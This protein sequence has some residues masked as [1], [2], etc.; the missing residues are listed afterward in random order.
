MKPLNFARVLETA[1]RFN[2]YVGVDKNSSSSMSIRVPPDSPERARDQRILNQLTNEQARAVAFE[3]DANGV[4]RD[5]RKTISDLASERLIGSNDLTPLHYLELAVSIARG[6]CR[7]RIGTDAGTGVLVGPRILMTNNHVIEDESQARAFEAQFDYQE[8]SSGDML[9]V[10]TFQG[11]PDHFF[12]TNAEL[13][14]TLVGLSAKSNRGV[15]IEKFPWSKLIGIPGK[16]AKGDPLNIIQHP[17]G[18]LKQ[19]AIRNNSIIKITDALP[20]F[21]YYT[22]DTQKGSSGSPCFNAHWEMVALHHDAMPEIKNSEIMTKSG[23]PWRKGID[24]ESMIKWIANEGT[25]VSAIVRDLKEANLKSSEEVIR[26]QMLNEEP[27]NP[28]EL[29]RRMNGTIE[30][31]CEENVMKKTHQVRNSDGSVSVNIPLH[32]NVALGASESHSV[33][34][35]SPENHPASK[36]SPRNLPNPRQITLADIAKEVAEIDPDWSNR[37][38]FEEDFLGMRVPLPTLSDAQQQSSV[39]VPAEFRRSGNPFVLDYYNYSVAMNSDRCLAWYSAAIIDGDKR[40]EMPDRNDKWFIDPRIDDVDDVQ[41]QCGEELYATA[42]TDRGHLTRY[43]DVAWGDTK[44]E[45]IRNAFDTLHFTNCCLMLQG[46]NRKRSRW[47]GIERFL[48]EKKAKREL[49]KLI[50]FT[51][52]LFDEEDPYYENQFMDYSVPIPKAFWKVCGIVRRDGT[53]SATAFVLRQDDVVGLPGFREAFTLTSEIQITIADLEERTGLQFDVLRDHDHL[54]DGGA[55]S[56]LE[57]HRRGE[58]TVAELPIR[59]FDDVVV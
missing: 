1:D 37:N 31:T 7:V 22:T 52:P 48:L 2:K 15:Q 54:A 17:R 50:V 33:S 35:V 4:R 6:V 36:E 42:K 13:D 5:P 30:S 23:R 8:N 34:D 14:F 57:I 21:L 26:D 32:I 28:V 44:A 38:G 10:H 46:F 55:L 9:P 40:F 19:V 41:F 45:A 16:S 3:A 56:T 12:Y 58:R 51:G 43:L 47:Q 18:G 49:R 53:L 11:A 29:A 59:S 27:P 39:A 20:D 25:R 24:D